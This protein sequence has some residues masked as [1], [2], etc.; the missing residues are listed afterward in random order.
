[1]DELCWGAG[2]KEMVLHN[3]EID[4][5]PIVKGAAPRGRILGFP[6]WTSAFRGHYWTGQNWRAALLRKGMNG[7]FSLWNDVNV[8]LGLL[9]DKCEYGRTATGIG[10]PA[11]ITVRL[12]TPA[13]ICRLKIL[14][15]FIF[16]NTSRQ[17]RFICD[18]K[19]TKHADVLNFQKQEMIVGP[20]SPSLLSHGQPL[21]L[22]TWFPDK[23]AP[24]NGME[25]SE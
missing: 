22:G 10:T 14:I 24:I 3:A 8:A 21:S 15:R 1:M 7:P 2:R 11:E 4:F 5:T 18:E 20:E 23:E 16:V 9:R 12:K 25:V 13:A 6:D 17:K 19:L